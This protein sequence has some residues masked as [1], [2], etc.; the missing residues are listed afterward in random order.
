M[1]R[2][3]VTADVTLFHSIRRQLRGGEVQ[4]PDDLGT[5]RWELGVGVTC[6][7]EVTLQAQHA[8]DLV[9]PDITICRY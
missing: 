1:W 7:V 4:P 5:V 8:G 6:S 9:I 2:F 3:Q